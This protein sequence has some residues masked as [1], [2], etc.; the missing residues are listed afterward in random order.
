MSLVVNLSS[1]NNRSPSDLKLPMLLDR[2]KDMK[3]EELIIATNATLDG[4]TTVYFITEYF[5]THPIKT[6]HLASGIPI[7]RA[8]DYLD[9]GTLHPAFESRK[10]FGFL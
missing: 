7:G 9:E 10:P 5:K 4:Q 3:T 8:L 1:P 6:T 2:C